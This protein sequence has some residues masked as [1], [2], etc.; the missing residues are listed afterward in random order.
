MKLH[1][2]PFLLRISCPNGN[3][4]QQIGAFYVDR[5]EFSDHHKFL[6]KVELVFCL[7]FDMRFLSCAVCSVLN[8]IIA[9]APFM[10]YMLYA[11]C[12]KHV[13]CKCPL[14][15]PSNLINIV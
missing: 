2:C 6:A 13:K 5:L 11:Y 15:L 1:T 7:L 8:Q 12:K 4:Y 3:D 14:L 10:P 9:Q